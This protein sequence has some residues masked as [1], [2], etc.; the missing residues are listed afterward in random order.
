MTNTEKKSHDN[1]DCRRGITS[2]PTA[3]RHPE[4]ML[5]YAEAVR[6]YSETDT[7][8]SDIA[9]RFGL[10]PSGL[11]VYIARHH[12]DI[13]LK[14]YGIVT[15]DC[16]KR[17]KQ[18]AGQSVYAYRKYKA[19]IRACS[20]IAFIEYNISQIAEMFGHNATSL[21]SQ[22]HFHYPDVIPEREKK[23]L[24]LG[25]ADNHRRGPRPECVEAYSQAVAMYRDTDMTVRDVAEA[26]KVSAGGL[27]QHLQF[28]CKSVVRQ[29][30]DRRISR[31][32]GEGPKRSGTLSGNGSKYGPNPETVE[33]YAKA[34]ELYRTS[35]MTLREIVSATG[36][37]YAG[38]RSYIRVW[39]G[40]DRRPG[41]RV[42]ASAAKYAPAIESLRKNP[43]KMTEVAAEYGLNPDALRDYLHR[44]APELAAARR[45]KAAGETP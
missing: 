35:G 45:L 24:E 43:R 30:A 27:S 29:K 44:H 26:C 5:K 17:I 40:D 4:A 37:P 42:M 20:D 14:K 1:V 8:L 28:Y 36:V 9:R 16:A 2:L 10:T 38:F 25:L 39:H 18:G 15:L 6:I 13:L 34:L 32:H 7:R 3:M 21:A 23:R 19:A 31:A 33:K 41:T 12:R 11:S 22:L